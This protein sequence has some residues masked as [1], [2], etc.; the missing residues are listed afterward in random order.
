M[1]RAVLAESDG[2][3]GVD[4]DGRDLH[5]GGHPDAVLRVLHEHQER[6]AVGPEA[7]VEQGAVH[8]G[9]HAELAD[10][11][12]DIVA[13]RVIAGDGLGAGVHGEVARGKIRGSAE[14]L[15]KERA[16]GVERVLAG[17]P[18]GNLLRMR[19]E[20]FDVLV[21]LLVEALGEPSLHAA[22]ELRGELRI[23]LAVGLE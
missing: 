18:G 14:E 3:V 19:L 22:D 11:V 17:L 10:A 8:D 13:G 15:G 1:G 4:E 20:V 5:E 16:V 23:L 7:A 2:V 6:C 21:S 9:G 12:V